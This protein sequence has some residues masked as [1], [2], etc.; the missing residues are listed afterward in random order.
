VRRRA[1]PDAKAVNA[2]TN[3]KTFDPERK[4]RRCRGFLCKPAIASVAPARFMPK[5]QE[6]RCNPRGQRLRP[7]RTIIRSG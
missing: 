4:P 2:E 3:R 7:R 1:R 6:W 5:L